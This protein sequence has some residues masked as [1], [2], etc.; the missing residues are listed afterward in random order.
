MEK[1]KIL[2]EVDGV[3]ELREIDYSVFRGKGETVYYPVLKDR[4][5]FYENEEK[6]VIF[7]SLVK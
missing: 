6:L 5:H 4:E 2:I 1:N 3:E 7:T